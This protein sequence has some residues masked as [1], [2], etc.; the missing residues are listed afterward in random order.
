LRIPTTAAKTEA[1]DNGSIVNGAAG[2]TS[3]STKGKKESSLHKAV[4]E[5]LEVKRAL[6]DMK[7]PS[8]SGTD[9]NGSVK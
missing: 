4:M 5:R 6:S 7:S 1:N 8:G 3:S 2:V 9:T